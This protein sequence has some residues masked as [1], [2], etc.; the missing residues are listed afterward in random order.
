M[1]CHI[2]NISSKKLRC[3]A[4][5]LRWDGTIWNRHF[6]RKNPSQ[7]ELRWQLRFRI[8]SFLRCIVTFWSLYLR[9]GIATFVA[10]FLRIATFHRKFLTI[11]SCDEKCDASSK[12]CDASSK[13]YDEKVALA[14][15]NRHFHR[16]FHRQ[17]VTMKTLHLRATSVATFD[18]KNWRW[19]SCDLKS[20]LPSQ[21]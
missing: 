4:K 16:N 21:V 17:K 6:H 15:W 12:C 18:V 5:N 3:N 13:S 14:I 9:C 10:T 19:P 2:A 11:A 1:R 8:A 20:Q 7:L